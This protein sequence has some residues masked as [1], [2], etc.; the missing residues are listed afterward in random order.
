MCT[1]VSGVCP[2]ARSFG[3]VEFWMRLKIPMTETVR[4]YRE[5]LKT[6]GHIHTALN[7]D[8]QVPLYYIC[9]L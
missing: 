2:E 1:C 8:P 9:Q 4:L 7:Q 6:A 5:K 3:S